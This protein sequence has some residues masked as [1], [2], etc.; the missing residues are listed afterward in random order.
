MRLGLLL[1]S[2][3]RAPPPPRQTPAL[4]TALPSPGQCTQ[5]STY[6]VSPYTPVW[7]ETRAAFNTQTCPHT[8]AHAH[9]RMHTH[10]T[11]TLTYMCPCI[12]T[13]PQCPHSHTC[14]C[15]HT[16]PHSTH[17]Q[18]SHTCPHTHTYTLNKERDRTG[19][20]HT[21]HRKQ[22]A[23]GPRWASR[24]PQVTQGWDLAAPRLGA[25]LTHR[26]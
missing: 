21:Q 1:L 19:G 9:T 4:C 5:N 16:C 23:A 13:C 14:P 24:P 3:C 15:I 11:V 7:E 18:H 10:S 6:H 2:T 26:P 25:F 22:T 12:H 17:T 20:P 8:H